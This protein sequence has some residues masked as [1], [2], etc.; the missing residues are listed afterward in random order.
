VDAGLAGITSSQWTEIG[1]SNIGG[2]IRAVIIDPDNTNNIWA[3][4]VSGGGPHCFA[5]G[6][7]QGVSFGVNYKF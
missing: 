2:R 6:R 5:G 3:G 7:L 1:P 4:G